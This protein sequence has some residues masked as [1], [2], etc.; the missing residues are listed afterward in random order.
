MKCKKFVSKRGFTLIEV[1][2]AVSIV[3]ILASLVVPK[4]TGYIDKARN[5]KVINTGKQIYTAA[6]WSFTDQGNVFKEAEILGTIKN[7]LGT[8]ATV[9]SG[10]TDVTV[11]FYTDNVECSVVITTA[12]NSY[13]IYKNSENIFASSGSLSK[14]TAQTSTP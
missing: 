1:I 14:T 3:V 4:V 5:A 6:M 12:D 13:K 8:G 7:T 11:K 10:T 2:I 9:T